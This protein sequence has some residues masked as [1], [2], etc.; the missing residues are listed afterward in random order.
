MTLKYEQISFRPRSKTIRK[1]T[2]I[3]NTKQLEQKEKLHWSKLN[4][5]N[6]AA[7]TNVDT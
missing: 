2:P 5:K 7:K 1:S 4:E 6:V 3:K